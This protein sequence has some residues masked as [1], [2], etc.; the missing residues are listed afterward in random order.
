MFIIGLLI[1]MIIGM[2]ITNLVRGNFN[3]DNIKFYK[4]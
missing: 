1:G 2:L 4:D 3:T